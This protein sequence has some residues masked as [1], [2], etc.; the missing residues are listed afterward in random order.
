MRAGSSMLAITPQAFRHSTRTHAL[1][2][3]DA[4]Y[5]TWVAQHRRV[6][7]LH[8]TKEVLPLSQFRLRSG[9]LLTDSAIVTC[10]YRV[11]LSRSPPMPLKVRLALHR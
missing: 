10:G 1:L 7:L 2:H 6:K 11:D 9:A 4:Q 8:E 3:R 5:S